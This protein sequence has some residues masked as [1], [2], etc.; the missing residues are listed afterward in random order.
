MSGP[1]GAGEYWKAQAMRSMGSAIVTARGAAGRGASWR[2]RLVI[3][4]H[5]HRR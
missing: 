3:F 2:C 4:V 1:I 5:R